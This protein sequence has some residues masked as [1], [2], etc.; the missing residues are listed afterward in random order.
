MRRWLLG[1]L[2]AALA[3]GPPTG[4]G[5]WSLPVRT[6]SVGLGLRVVA[7]TAQLRKTLGIRAE[8]GA[9]VL[10]VEPGGPAAKGGVQAGDVLTHVAAVPV[11]DAGDILDALL[12]RTPGSRVRVAFVRDRE[13]RVATITLEAARQRHVR[14]GGRW[15]T[16]PTFGVPDDAERQL[17]GFRQR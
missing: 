15:F 6:V 14:M 5:T 2:V 3:V 13:E 11:G 10:E 17:R 4:P 12:D 16:L 9:L 7:T 1:S 8:K